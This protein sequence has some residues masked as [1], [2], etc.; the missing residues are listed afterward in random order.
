MKRINTF[1]IKGTK[2]KITRL[3][4]PDGIGQI[5]EFKPTDKKEKMKCKHERK[6][7][8]GNMDRKKDY[9]KC[10]DC[11]KR[12]INDSMQTQTIEECK[13]IC[14]NDYFRC[15]HCFGYTKQDIIAQERARLIKE[16]DKMLNDDKYYGEDSEFL[17]GAFE[18][19]VL[20]LLGEK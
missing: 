12:V 6:L 3:E 2:I 8:C 1:K 4:N 20:K 10:V 9:W 14:H 18:R 16:V 15:K 17:V 11:G 19:D 7:H 13:C 5:I